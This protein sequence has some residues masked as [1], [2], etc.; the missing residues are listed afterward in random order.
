MLGRG[1]LN[2]VRNDVNHLDICSICRFT[3][4][5]FTSEAHVVFFEVVP[6]LSFFSVSWEILVCYWLLCCSEQEHLIW[7]RPMIKFLTISLCLIFELFSVSDN[8]WDQL[9]FSHIAIPSN[10]DAYIVA[11]HH[12]NW[13]LWK[14]KN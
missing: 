8:T 2:T 7:C 9:F 13:E 6:L 4:M 11:E 12:I 5:S 3:I 10:Q 1:S 14:N